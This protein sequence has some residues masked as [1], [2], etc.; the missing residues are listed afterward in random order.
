VK[1]LYL[2][3]WLTVVAALALFG[4][5]SA[6]LLQRHLD[7]EW[8]RA[9]AHVNERLE[10][11]ADLIQNSLPPAE[12]T[13]AEQATQLREWARRLKMPLA[14]DDAYGTRIG[15]SDSYSDR[16][17]QAR[18]GDPD[19]ARTTAIRLADGRTLY[20]MRPG[21]IGG[22]P[23]P[24]MD[25]PPGGPPPGAPDGDD[26]DFAGRP[27]PDRASGPSLRVP[28]DLSVPGTRSFAE[29]TREPGGVRLLPDGGSTVLQMPPVGDGPPNGPAALGRLG[30]LPPLLP[31]W[32]RDW[33]AGLGLVVLLGVLFLA[34]AGGAYP[35][36]RRLTRRLE[37]LKLG[38]ER[39]GSGELDHRV[40]ARGRDEVAAVAT[41][42][43]LAAQRVQALLHANQRLLANASH[44]LRSPL[45]RMKMAISMLADMPAEAKQRGA[46]EREINEN[47]AELDALVEEVLLS[48]RLEAGAPVE[49]GDPVDLL[50]LCAEE[51]A[52]VNAEVEGDNVTVRGSER[53]L[54]RAVRNLA[55]NA[56]R[57]GGDEDR[58]I[59]LIGQPAGAD[60]RVLVCDRGPGVP[61]AERERIFEPFYRMKGHA[62]Q[63]GGVGLGL[64]LVQQIAQT[65]GGRVRCLAH[66]GGGSCFEFTMPNDRRMP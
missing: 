27:P 65:H 30:K 40:D 25:G 33:P 60:I 15:A 17:Y 57:Y 64:A 52:R 55:E 6:W 26:D 49:L 62:E 51:G 34:V 7:S 45:A 31:F 14:L 10:A 21:R 12:A 18:R 22:P 59:R 35:V 58:T 8:A 1:S 66:E 3:I 50:A 42:F 19:R 23:D 43:N 29:A 39:F 47:I 36:V 5:S 38:V 20:M 53:L 46:L 56:R 48:S 37:R 2:R 24:H 41:S 28:E 44:E 11:W 63:Q 16:E 61:E 9:E 32:P 13:R 4:L 54:R